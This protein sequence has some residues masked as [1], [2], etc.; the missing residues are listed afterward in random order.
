MRTAPAPR[1]ARTDSSGGV[2]WRAGKGHKP[3]AAPSPSL[4]LQPLTGSPGWGDERGFD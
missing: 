1:S 3:S 2:L 4:G